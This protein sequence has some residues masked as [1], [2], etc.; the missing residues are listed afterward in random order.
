[1]SFSRMLTWMMQVCSLL[2]DSKYLSPEERKK[3]ATKILSQNH[4]YHN[5]KISLTVPEDAE[6]LPKLSQGWRNP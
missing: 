2:R 1:M 4:Y 6:G 5:D 3:I